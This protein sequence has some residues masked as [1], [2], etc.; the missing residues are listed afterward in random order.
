MNK[1]DKIRYLRLY[2]LAWGGGFIYLLHKN[3]RN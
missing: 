3:T 2:I 1:H